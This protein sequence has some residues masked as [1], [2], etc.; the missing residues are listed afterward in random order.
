[1]AKGDFVWCDLSS[2]RVVETKSFYGR[3]FGWT[4]DRLTQPDGTAYE[5]AATPAGEAGAIFEMPET[6]QTLGLPSFW[7]PYIAVDSVETACEQASRAG[8]KVEVGP[9]AWSGE[10]RIALIRDPLGA[11]FTVHQ[12]RGLKPRSAGEAPG[13]RAWCALYVSDVGAVRDF[14]ETLFDW[15]IS[16]DPTLSGGFRVRNARGVAVADIL[17][18]SDELRGRYQF[19]GVH[20]AVSD[21]PEAIGEIERSGGEIVYR[22]QSPG[23]STVLAKD[24]DGA[25]FF[26]REAPSSQAKRRPAQPPAVRA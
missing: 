22:D 19:W 26:I 9:L 6:F 11:G 25:A 18:L 7:M 24:P 10:D 16:A 2:I 13:Q 12:G 23:L 17:E 1:M 5:V 4:Y 21:L 3:L 20:F 8:G 15:R 14:Y